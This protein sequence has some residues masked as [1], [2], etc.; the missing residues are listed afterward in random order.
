[1]GT[2]AEGNNTSPG[3]FRRIDYLKIAIF[4]F[5]LNALWNPMSTIIMPLLVLQFVAESQKN[6]YLGILTFSGLALAIIV[7][8]AA[9]AISDRSGFRWGRRRPYILAGVFISVLLL[10][11]FSLAQSIFAVFVIYCCLQISSNV[12]HGPWQGLIPDLVP[13][14]KRGIAS[15][16]KGIFE[17][18]GAVIGIQLTGY[19][20]S[21]RFIAEEDTKILLSVAIIAAI[22]II[23]MLATV[24]TV[25]EGPAAGGEKGSPLPALVKTF[26]INVRAQ[27]SFIF[28]LLSR[29]LFLMPLVILRTFGLYY[30]RDIALVADPVATAADLTMVVGICLLVVVYPAGHLS[31]WIGRRPILMISGLIA[32]LAFVMLL[33]LHEYVYILIAGGLLGVA[34]GGFMSVNW[35][36]AT[37]LVPDGE[38]ARY[39]GLTNLATAGASAL[40]T[41]AGPVIDFFNRYTA[42]LGYQVVFVVCI[43]LLVISSLLV[44]K[45]R[46]SNTSRRLT[47]SI[48]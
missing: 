18:L 21:D 39:L 12:A 4:G 17:V 16:V 3:L 42:N 34:N 41:I 29:L 5:A 31:D 25:R 24:L 33:V 23:A 43:V 27:R 15:G 48:R 11:T 37:D 14:T 28:F 22:M 45:I 46:V 19:I 47:A 13:G 6:T 38:E 2:V 30:F 40:A 10:P 20:L 32:A 26:T 8:P 35:A 9:G 36:M 1:M 7:Q 44:L